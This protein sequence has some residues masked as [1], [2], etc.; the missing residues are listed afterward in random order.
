MT[1][2]KK[3][4]KMNADS[5]LVWQPSNYSLAHIVLVINS[6]GVTCSIR[7]DLIVCHIPS[8]YSA[9]NTVNISVI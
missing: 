5:D 9:L 1:W 8:M 6:Y 4:G 2:K 7:S 3:K